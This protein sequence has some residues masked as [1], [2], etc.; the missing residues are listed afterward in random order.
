MKFKII[1]ATSIFLFINAF[2]FCEEKDEEILYSRYPTGEKNVVLIKLDKNK[3][4][5]RG[6][7]QNGN[8]RFEETIING[9]KEGDYSYWFDNGQISTKG[10]YKND[11]Y[12]GKSI[13]YNT[14]GSIS[15]E[16]IYEDNGKLSYWIENEITTYAIETKKL[17]S[18]RKVHEYIAKDNDLDTDEETLLRIASGST[19]KTF[20]KFDKYEYILSIEAGGPVGR[21]AQWNGPI[22]LFGKYKDTYENIGKLEG[23]NVNIE[24]HHYDNKK[25]ELIFKTN[26]HMS[27]RSG[28]TSKYK[29]N[30]KNFYLDEAIEEEFNDEGKVI[31]STK[32]K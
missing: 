28:V 24:V 8:K 7:Y 3:L 29:W 19:N 18:L 22:Y 32:I 30:G 6:Y 15:K 23:Q 21:G 9:Y 12:F 4:L 16:C 26:W 13:S 1:I 2:I 25:E 31:K 20:Q 10:Q 17:P 5:R 27:A 14:D 11:N